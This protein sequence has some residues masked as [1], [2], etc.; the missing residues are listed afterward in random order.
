MDCNG[1]KGDNDFLG[2]NDF[3]ENKDLL[4]FLPNLSTAGITEGHSTSFK[5]F[6]YLAVATIIIILALEHLA[7]RQFIT[8]A[9]RFFF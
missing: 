6:I 8:T 9:S 4:E 1:V 5:V 2:D 7:V 3:H